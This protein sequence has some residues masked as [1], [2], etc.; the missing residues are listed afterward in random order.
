MVVVGDEVG[1]QF[2]VRDLVCFFEPTGLNTIME[3]NHKKA[4]IVPPAM[5]LGLFYKPSSRSQA[6]RPGKAF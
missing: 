1:A 3:I 4:R 6:S 2:S 5:P